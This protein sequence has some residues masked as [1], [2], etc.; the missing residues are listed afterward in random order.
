MDL[1]TVT[2]LV[3]DMM[4]QGLGLDLS[5]PNLCQTPVRIAKMYCNEFF[6]G[7]GKEFEKEDLA[8]FPNSEGVDEIVMLD[9]IRFV[10]ICAH[11]FLPFFGRAWFLYIPSS[12]LV[13]ASKVARLIDH[14][15]S[16]PQL[17]E[18]LCHQIVTRFVELVQPLGAML[19]MRAIHGCM[20]CRGVHQY[21]NA[22]M[23]SSAV[24]GSF[25]EDLRTRSE[26]LS[27]INLSVVEGGR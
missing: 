4:V 27:L 13:G 2:A 16:R 24:W 6:K 5:D 8:V 21:D 11:H 1:V 3:R 7:V 9:N 18:N 15:S 23:V 22:G 25:K 19:I 17:Q 14:Y 26:G 12:S 20:T 10:S